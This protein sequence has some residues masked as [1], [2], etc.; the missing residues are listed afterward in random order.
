MS[1]VPFNSITGHFA[2]CKVVMNEKDYCDV[3]SRLIGIR[4]MI[5]EAGHNCT[6]SDRTYEFSFQ[7]STLLP[8]EPMRAEGAGR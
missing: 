1:T 3:I 5:V 8:N 4:K 2:T 7:A 6:G